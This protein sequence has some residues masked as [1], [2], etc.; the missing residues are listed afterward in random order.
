M[1][2]K[3]TMKYCQSVQEQLKNHQ[4]LKKFFFYNFMLYR[5]VMGAYRL[6]NE[7]NSLNMINLTHSSTVTV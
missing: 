5:N 3:C 7:T 6:Y 4:G 2:S 1:V